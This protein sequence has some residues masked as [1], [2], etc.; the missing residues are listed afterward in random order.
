MSSIIVELQSGPRYFTRVADD[1]F[2][3]FDARVLA[4]YRDYIITSPNA[5]FIPEPFVF[6]EAL[7]RPHRDG[8]LGVYD[9]FQWPQ[10]HCDIYMWAGCIPR[11][12]TYRDNVIWKWC[13]WNVT[14]KPED[15][16]QEVGSTFEVGRVHREKYQR[17]NSVYVDLQERVQSWK[18]RDTRYTGPLKVDAW[19]GAVA[20]TFERLKR[21]MAR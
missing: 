6:D 4:T 19:M 8:R 5:D 21:F 13:W 2:S 11:E 20:R 15:F 12:D 3:P 17:L 9:C 10:L 14:Q 16:T 18:K 1:K 7:I